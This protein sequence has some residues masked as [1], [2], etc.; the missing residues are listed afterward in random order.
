MRAKVD[1]LYIAIALGAAC[2]AVQEVSIA[3]GEM[4]RVPHSAPLAAECG[5]RTLTHYRF[6]VA[7]LSE[8]IADQFDW[9][10][11]P[12]RTRSSILPIFNR[13]LNYQAKQNENHLHSGTRGGEDAA[14]QSTL[15]QAATA[16]LIQRRR[17][18][19]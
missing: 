11:N 15:Q 8:R 7:F 17:R 10:L 6:R 3:T 14:Q 16:C 12:Q 13:F 2:T 4:G 9:Q 19:V 5:E 18:L 1:M